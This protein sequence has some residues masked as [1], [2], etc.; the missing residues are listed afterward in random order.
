MLLDE[1][2]YVEA[3]VTAAEL[4]V[5][6]HLVDGRLLRVSR[7]GRAA[8]TPAYWRTTGCVA[9]G[10]PRAGAG[11][12]RRRPGWSGRVRCSTARIAHFG[13]DDGGFFDTADDAEA[14][15]ARPRDPSDNASP[16]GLL[17]DGRG[18]GHLRRAD[19]VGHA[20][21]PA[22]AALRAVRQLAERAPRFA[23]WSLAAA[24]AMVAGPLE[25]AVV[26]D[27][28]ELAA[29]ARR[30][31]SPGAVVVVNASGVPLMEGRDA[32]RRSE[33]GVRLP[34]DG[35]RAAGDDSGPSTREDLVSEHSRGLQT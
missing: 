34:R 25:I 2:R 24:E 33:R 8:R 23:G 4:L 10:L 17:R 21:R 1:P 22:E 9:D 12:G 3:A 28:L 15:V 29:A 16:S 27:D 11:D 7:D 5:S 14:L 6:L 13:S 31:T 30:T 19:R 18:A 32:R 26:G 35:L 20:P